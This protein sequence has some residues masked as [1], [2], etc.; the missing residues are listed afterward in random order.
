MIAVLNAFNFDVSETELPKGAAETKELA[1]QKK[2]D[3]IRQQRQAK[4]KRK[5]FISYTSV[6]A[7]QFLTTKTPN[8]NELND[9]E[10][11]KE[12]TPNQRILATVLGVVLPRLRKCIQPS[13]NIV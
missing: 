4:S 7:Q 11:L 10:K 1:R 8:L 12:L 13:V 5:Q 6:H 9:E 3:T 2:L